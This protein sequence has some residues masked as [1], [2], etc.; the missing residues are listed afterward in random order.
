MSLSIELWIRT[1]SS[2]SGVSISETVSELAAS[3]RNHL[4]YKTRR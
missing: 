3:A 4:S 2:I 1:T